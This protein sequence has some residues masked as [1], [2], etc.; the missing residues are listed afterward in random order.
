MFERYTEKARRVLLFARQKASA[1]GSSYIESQ[2]LLLGILQEIPS[3]I[4]LQFPQKLEQIKSELLAQEIKGAKAPDLGLPLSNECKRILAHAAE[5]A[6]RLNHRHIGTEHLFLGVL[7]EEKC[8]AAKVLRSH[9][10]SLED[11]RLR[12][13]RDSELHSVTSRRVVDEF[14]TPGVG[15][16][17]VVGRAAAGQRQIEFHNE[18]DDSILGTAP[19]FDV[20]RIGDEIF[21]EA[22]QGRVTRVV[23]KYEASPEDGLLMR[24]RIAIYVRLA[25]N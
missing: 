24:Q 5:E 22:L 9:G 13:Q 11:E 16:G 6:E 18:A 8:R 7:R 19:G 21:L 20:P 10:I 1:D 17:V 23:H 4:N 25:P 12:I 15:S 2:H 3:V 14:A